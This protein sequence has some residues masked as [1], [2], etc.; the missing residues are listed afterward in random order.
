[1]S[2]ADTGPIGR[3]QASLATLL[4]VVSLIA[5]PSG[6]SAQDPGDLVNP[7]ELE[8]IVISASG[9]EQV[10]INA[11]ASITV[12]TSEELARRR[13]T[14]LPELLMDVEGIDVAGSPGKTGNVSVSMRGMPSDYTLILIDGRRQNSAGSVTPNGFGGTSFGFLP[15]PSAIERVE[16][17]R[18]PM[19]TLYGSD[20]MGGVINI[21][22]KKVATGW[23]GTGSTDVTVQEEQDFGN[24]YTQSLSANG[25]LVRDRLG[26]D[27]RGSLM[28][29]EEALL[30][31]SGDFDESVTISRRGPSPVQSDRYSFGGRLVFT[32]N[33]DHD[34]SLEFDRSRQ[35]YDNSEAQ[36]GTLD[37][38]E[39]DFF[40][41][42][43][44]EQRFNRDQSVL[45]HTWRFGRGAL[46]SS[47]MRN[48]TETIGRTLPPGTPG[49]PPGS[50]APDKEA[51]SARTL[52]SVNFVV[53]SKATW[54]FTG[55][56]LTLGGQL[57]DAEMIDAVALNPFAST[58]W[59]LFAEDEWRFVPAMALTLGGRYDQHDTF[60][61]QLSPRA[62][63][64]WNA[65]SA[66]TLKGGVSAGYKTPN[67][68]RLQ[69][70]IIG[71]SG[72]GTRP[73]IGTPSL[74]PETSLSSEL[75]LYY[76][77]NGFSGN[78]S[79][80]NND[81]RDKITS[82][83]DIPNCSFAGAPD[84][85]G[86][87]DFGDFPSLEFYSQQVNVDEAVTRGVEL[88]FRVPLGEVLSLSGNYTYTDSE[89]RS[90]E[91]EGFPLTNTPAHMVNGSLRATVGD[92]VSAWLRGEYKS[93]R[94]RSTSANPR[95]NTLAAMEALGDY[96]AYELFHL[97]G[98]YTVQRV[99]LSA[100]IYNV[101][102]KDFLIY[103]SYQGTPTEDNP[104]GIQYSN[105]YNNHQEGRRLWLSMG[106]NF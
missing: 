15:P 17:I 87:L 29:R 73:Y 84:L 56:R 60:G 2:H 40:R 96:R 45:A 22:T 49:G 21:I 24:V 62:Y 42:Y 69:E 104:S 33:A 32:P 7:I 81:F 80:F 36:L 61:S 98:S 78:V 41:G 43:G 106:F 95:G 4:G 16:I 52:E 90:G 57:W 82:G 102:N 53:D 44:P 70:G 39:T 79:L 20:A 13:T 97:G 14:T 68:E 30:S 11:P 89:Q 8:E 76:A 12:L 28:Y 100:T 85:P 37:D 83:E 26:L 23:S 67:V 91:D 18:G 5:A 3:G 101:L 47:I 9:F 55:H 77:S 38:P 46:Q 54:A 63:L 35:T 71:F 64:V 25:P 19:A 103:R 27:L 34:V 50:G 6:I 86:C 31:P 94:A 88:A 74:K 92:G 75:G 93:A 105:L 1:M 59:S 99:T 51:G 10:R 65:T 58:Q 48:M 72:Q 66:W